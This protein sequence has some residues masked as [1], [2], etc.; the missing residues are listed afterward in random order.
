MSKNINTH[1][2][3][4]LSVLSLLICI[5]PSF[6]DGDYN[7]RLGDINGDGSID[8]ADV[9]Y[10]FKHRN[11]PIEDGDLNC[12]NSIDIADVVYLFKNYDKYRE[13]I[14]YAN[15]IKITYYDS[16]G[17]EV[18]PYNGDSYAYKIVEDATG[19]KFLLK[20]ASQSIPSWAN[21]KYDKVI[22]VPLKNVV[23]M[24]STHIAL[25]EPL[26]TDGSVIASV[27]GIMWGGKYKWYFKDI[28]EG[29]KNGSIIDVGSSY[30]PNYD[31]I[32][33]ISPQVVF[34]YPGYSGNGIIA[35]CKDLNIT[36]VADAEYL[37]D[38]YLARCE[39][40]KMFAAFYNK[41]DVANKYFTKV[42]KKAL[43]VRRLTRGKEPVSVAWGSKSSWGTYV[44]KAQSYVA[45]AIMDDC[46]GNYI[47]SDYP[48]T[49]STNIDYET[50]AERAKSADVWVVPSSTTWL[51]S[52]KDNNPGYDTFK[53]VQNGRIFCISGD[54]WQLGLM[55]TD[56]VLMDLGTIIHP[57]AFKGRTTH[58]F[59]RYYPN[60]NTAVPYTAN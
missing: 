52:F 53:S 5:T 25:M 48:G 60:N 39:W 45:K 42:E 11:V 30:S 16:N 35:K 40:V 57:D 51:S 12:D 8:I 59:L 55:N 18:N 36:Y 21:G 58:Y 26:N 9:V 7:H 54:Y 27:K 29:L 41:E 47:F 37:E 6:A 14:H 10:L 15:D 2:M 1:P 31:E 32:I 38:S 43:N 20:N 24:S 13:P 46:H 56:E 50:F 44:P 3:I 33:N 23:V 34:V 19:Q 17:N 49:G 22:N 28:E 4:I